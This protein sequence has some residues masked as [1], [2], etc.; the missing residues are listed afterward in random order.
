M[1]AGHP[2]QKTNTCICPQTELSMGQPPT[3]AQGYRYRIHQ[4]TSFSY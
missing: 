2:G 1:L 3:I 4:H